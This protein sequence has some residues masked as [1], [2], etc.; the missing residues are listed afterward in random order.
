MVIIGSCGEL[1]VL[2]QPHSSKDLHFLVAGQY[3]VTHLS[4]TVPNEI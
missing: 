4:E 2:T 1:K 3:T